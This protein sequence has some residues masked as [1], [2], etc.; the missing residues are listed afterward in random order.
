ML[1]SQG[2][3]E[4]RIEVFVK[5]QKKIGGGGGG[6][7]RGWIGLG[8]GGGARSGWERGGGSGRM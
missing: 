8:G 2:E 5:I 3:C 1:G 4:Q 6:L 7:G